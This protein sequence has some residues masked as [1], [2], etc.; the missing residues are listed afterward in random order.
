MGWSERDGKGLQDVGHTTAEF[1][2]QPLR[3]KAGTSQSPALPPVDLV[4]RESGTPP[5]RM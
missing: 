2:R 3:G 1:L 4:R 5:S